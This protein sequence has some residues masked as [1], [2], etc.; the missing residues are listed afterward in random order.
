MCNYEREGGEASIQAVEF[1]VDNPKF[2]NLRLNLVYAHS[3][4]NAIHIQ[5][6]MLTAHKS[7]A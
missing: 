6:H 4:Q 5:I 1:C 3:E 2:M 7:N